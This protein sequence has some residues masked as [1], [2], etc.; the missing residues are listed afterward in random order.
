MTAALQASI[1]TVLVLI[2][3][4]DVRADST[5]SLDSLIEQSRGE[6]R[7]IDLA[8]VAAAKK[9]LLYAITALEIELRSHD[10]ATASQYRKA[11]RLSE[12]K[13]MVL[14][15]GEI[16]FR[17]LM[18]FKTTIENESPP[19]SLFELGRFR[20]AALTYVERE[21]YN[22]DPYLEKRFSMR[23]DRLA[24]NV[25]AFAAEPSSTIRSEIAADAAWL[26]SAN[27][28]HELVKQIHRRFAHPNFVTRVSDQFFE[29]TGSKEIREIKPVKQ[30]I[31]GAD[32]TGESSTVGKVYLKPLA[33][34][35]GLKFEIVLVGVAISD[36]IGVKEGTRVTSSGRTEISAHRTFELGGDGVRLNPV[37]ASATT[38]SRIKSVTTSS[39]MLQPFAWRV[40]ESMRPDSEKISAAQSRELLAREFADVTNSSI[41]KV[42]KLFF[43]HVYSPLSSVNS[44]PEDVSFHT[45]NQAAFASFKQ[46]SD[47]QL[48]ASGPPPEVR[49]DRDIMVQMHESALHNLAES[50]LAGKTFTTN[51]LAELTF[52]GEKLIA[53]KD[54]E[55][56]DYLS[57]TFAHIS[58]LVLDFRNDRLYAKLNIA[59]AKTE[60]KKVGP[61]SIE[62]AYKVEFKNGHCFLTRDGEVQVTAQKQNLKIYEIAA[63][64]VIKGRCEEALPA[65]VEFGDE[66][67]VADLMIAELKIKDGWLS[68]GCDYVGQ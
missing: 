1:F 53:P 52:G 58:P 17:K 43:S 48:S 40:A 22:R 30:D 28:S 14:S 10:R 8:E 11:F 50:F 67:L 66:L 54:A 29:K 27:Q 4:P 18:E 51:D 49:F 45:T 32:V 5:A 3:G 23:M 64:R 35:D 41:E 20:A 15:G 44:F 19:V 37:K 2:A 68:M 13:T 47:R 21:F 36:T 39:M 6:F 26:E 9:K 31:N 46:A 7:P 42:E 34:S 62:A 63:K 56:I 33:T 24:K 61:I 65:T 25:A 12:L 55:A 16:D 38:S 57:I 60:H 59:L